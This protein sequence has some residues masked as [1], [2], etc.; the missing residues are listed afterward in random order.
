MAK[1]VSDKFREKFYCEVTFFQ[2]NSVKLEGKFETSLVEQQVNKR[3]SLTAEKQQEIEVI[4]G[5][6]SVI[7]SKANI[8]ISKII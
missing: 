6:M 3:Q 4:N 7:S 1:R 8:Q 2:L 5:A